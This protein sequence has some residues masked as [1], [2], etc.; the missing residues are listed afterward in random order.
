MARKKLQKRLT[1]ILDKQ[2]LAD[3][4]RRQPELVAVIGE[5]VK[6]GATENE[7]ERAVTNKNRHMWVQGQFAKSVFRALKA[8]RDD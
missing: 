1:A 7:V 4:D 5:F 2:N 8:Q 6:D 3:L